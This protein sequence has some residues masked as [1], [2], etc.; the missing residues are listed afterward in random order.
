M[1]QQPQTPVMRSFT[2]AFKIPILIGKFEGGV[3]LPGGPYSLV[4]I[5]TAIATYLAAIMLRPF[6]G[7][8]GIADFLAAAIP[9]LTIGFFA[10]KISFGARGPIAIATSLLGG[11]TS[12]SFGSYRG[13]PMVW[14]TRT[15][16]EL[17]PARGG[18]RVLVIANSVTDSV[19]DSVTGGATDDPLSPGTATS[20][21]VQPLLSAPTR[22]PG[23]ALAPP[24][25][26]QPRPHPRLRLRSSP[27][28]GGRGPSP[29]RPATVP[30]PAGRT[31]DLAP[32]VPGGAR[33]PVTAVER[34]LAAAE[35]VS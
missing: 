25:A 34:L 1:T 8:W 28:R 19:T 33:V 2:R 31:P 12:P 6:W 10:G 15:L 26:G 11:M 32:P 17:L 30:A 14:P 5:L 20:A 4:Q 16:T 22:P 29:R 23:D 24:A 9:A 13:K 3:S 27:R 18:Y 7:Q 21:P 35:K